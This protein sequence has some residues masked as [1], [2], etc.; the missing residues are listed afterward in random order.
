MGSAQANKY[1]TA[2]LPNR[3]TFP[4]VTQGILA[5]FFGC[6]FHLSNEHSKNFEQTSNRSLQRGDE[7]SHE[8][9]RQIF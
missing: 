5:I 9:K 4:H 6:D 1:L 3:S 7:T 2:E 8:E